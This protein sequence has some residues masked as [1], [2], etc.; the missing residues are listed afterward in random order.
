MGTGPLS[1]EDTQK[2]ED[3]VGEGIYHVYTVGT[4][5]PSTCHF[6]E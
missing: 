4:V 3:L 6:A 5:D 1:L 2:L